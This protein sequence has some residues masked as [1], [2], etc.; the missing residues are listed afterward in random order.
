MGGEPGGRGA[1]GGP[2]ATGVS[3]LADTSPGGELWARCAAWADHHVPG[4]RAVKALA[5]MPGNAGLSFGLDIA[6]DGGGMHRVV[7][8]LAPPGV[9]RRGS[10]DVLSQVP[11]LDFLAGTSVPI[12]RLEFSTDDP[13][14]FGTDAIVQER[15]AGESMNVRDASW[16]GREDAAR[17]R[18]SS[19]LE[20][21]ARVH[22]LD[23]SG[24]LPG[25]DVVDSVA[26]ETA[27]WSRLL[28]KSGEGGLVARGL[29]LRDGLLAAEPR[30]H[31]IGLTHGDFQTNNVLFD[32]ATHGVT[33]VVDWELAGI[34]PVGRDLGWLAMMLDPEVWAPEWAEAL[35]V[36]IAPEEVA[37][38]YAGHA[39]G[40]VSSGGG[41]AGAGGGAGGVADFA[42]H[43]AFACF[44][45]GSIV[46]FNHYL[47]R[48]GKR[49]DPIYDRLASSRET[50]FAAGERILA[51]G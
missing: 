24:G 8:R 50:R 16:A 21:L 51:G 26:E 12:A 5:P 40:G 23:V 37:E 48:T 35:S 3:D 47:H 28:E 36:R 18:L 15:L 34:G 32:P 31:A 11:L 38:M 1:A 17:R 4:A 14:W 46:S 41:G 10:T 43:R 25:K 27:L 20:A 7:I 9:P 30:D 22:A 39:G 6:L 19:A 42:W 33:G 2:G 49:V 45:Y 29:K 13:R 44:K